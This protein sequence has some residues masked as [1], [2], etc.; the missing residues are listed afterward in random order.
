MKKILFSPDMQ[1]HHEVKPPIKKPVALKH[2]HCVNPQPGIYYL[3]F[4]AGNL[5]TQQY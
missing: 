2:I 5:L 3:N 1:G 4:D